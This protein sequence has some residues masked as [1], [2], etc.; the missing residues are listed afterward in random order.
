MANDKVSFSQDGLV[1]FRKHHY[2]RGFYVCLFCITLPIF[3]F[4]MVVVNI[5]INA[6]K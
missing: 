5:L 6:V 2:W 3:V 1:K 4:F